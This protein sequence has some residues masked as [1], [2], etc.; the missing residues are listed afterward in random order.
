[1]KNQKSSPPDM[2]QVT[3]FLVD[4]CVGQIP[5]N[6]ED[7]S[8]YNLSERAALVAAFDGCGGSGAKKYS[9]AG[10]KTGAYIAARAV[11]STVNT[12]F[13]GSRQRDADRLHDQILEV[14]QKCH[15]LASESSGL[16]GRLTKLFPT[17]MAAAVCELGEE[18][19]Y[20]D[21]YWAGDSRIYL[22]DADGIAQLTRD[23]I[24]DVDA[25]EN[26][27]ADEVL[28]NVV[29]LSVPFT[30]HT[31]RI[32]PRKPCLILAA[33]DGSFGYLSTPMEFEYLL[34][35]TLLK[36]ESVAEWEQELT[37]RIGAV[38]GD[39]YT[40]CGVS[41]GFGSLSALK[42]QLFPRAEALYEQYVHPLE[43]AD[44][45]ERLELWKQYQ[46]E[47]YRYLNRI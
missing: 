11:K 25:M 14:L 47:Y 17:T 38:A 44:S 22:L 34:L 7:T 24:G 29:N 15:Q 27:S 37:R 2:L 26:L 33:T 39:D 12:W 42:N 41:L 6:G 16:I 3:D 35:E 4:I 32:E 18:G 36:S 5:E 28:T 45:R 31:A 43:Q 30:I 8:L 46:S 10:N 40:V 20:A 21:L 19:L 1:M 9:R 23:D 13:E